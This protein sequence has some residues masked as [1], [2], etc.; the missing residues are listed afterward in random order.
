MLFICSLIN[1]EIVYLY[2]IRDIILAID[3]K[4]CN[5]M[6]T[7]NIKFN[8]GDVVVDGKRYK[9]NFIED[10]ALKFC[11]LVNSTGNDYIV[12]LDNKNIWTF[13]CMLAT[14]VCKKT[15]VFIS[16]SL[17][18]NSKENILNELE[19]NQIYDEEYLREYYEHNKE[20]K[21]Y[22]S[23]QEQW[24][25]TNR[26]FISYIIYTSGTTGKPKGVMIPF[27]SVY[28]TISG[29]NELYRITKEDTI[30]NLARWSFDLS[31]FDAFST[32]LYGATMVCINDPQ[33]AQHVAKAIK[34]NKVTIW[35]STPQV[36]GIFV[37]YLKLFNKAKIPT[38]RLTLISGDK[39]EKYICDLAILYFTNSKIISLGGAT[40]CSIWSV[41]YDCTEGFDNKYA[42]YG[43]ALPN[44]KIEISAEENNK[45][46][47][48]ISG[49]SLS[50]GYYHNDIQTKKHFKSENGVKKYYTGDIGYIDKN[51][52][53]YIRGRK[54]SQKKIS[55]K[56][57][58][59]DDISSLFYKNGGQSAVCITNEAQTKLAV[60]IKKGS[61]SKENI[62][63]IISKNSLSDVLNVRDV[64]ELSDFPLSQNGKINEPK[65]LE[66][67]NEK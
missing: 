31:I 66:I 40:E 57:Y 12:L 24:D 27:S 47:I 41:K 67:W 14:I 10:L 1:I 44:Q 49:N 17:S 5:L 6:E 33:N 32:I 48:V 19:V 60:F 9:S 34:L 42:P 63:S 55:G 39:F 28:N 45:N 13:S 16:D 56:R 50:A 38:I 36:L 58:V 51:G 29:M 18:E 62:R 61:I 11:K 43:Y 46:E 22:G 59:L 8:V 4:R 37:K 3:K 2:K 20:Y 30:L 21:E 25:K 54:D 35:N 15:F 7:I 65:L 53:M 23:L 26:D 52:C 64:I